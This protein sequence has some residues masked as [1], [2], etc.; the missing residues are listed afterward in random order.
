MGLCPN[1]KVSGGK[2][3]R[4]GFMPGQQWL[5]KMLRHAAASLARNESPLGDHYRRMRGRLGPIGANTVVAHK[6]ARILWHLV[7]HQQEYDESVLVKLDAG[8]DIRRLA[9]LPRQA[10]ALHLQ[11]VPFPTPPPTPPTPDQKAA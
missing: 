9:R 10:Q 11:L 7:T 3:L 1:H 8:R 5:R 4:R 6:L 2:V